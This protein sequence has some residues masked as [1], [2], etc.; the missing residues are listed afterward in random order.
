MTPPLAPA[1]GA[2]A[3]LRAAVRSTVR[4]LGAA[5]ALLYAVDRA[6]DRASRGRVRLF[7]YDLVAQ[8][9]PAAGM[10]AG[11]RAGGA[12]AIHGVAAGD[13]LTAAFPRPPEVIAARYRAGARCLAATVRGTF[14]GFLWWARGD[15]EEDEVRAT[16]VLADATRCAWDYDV[17][18]APEFRLGR[19]LARL[20][21]AA[22]ERLAADGVAWTLS[23]ISAF[24]AASHAAH[25]RL[26]LR[27]V[28]RA[29]FLRAGPVQLGLWTGPPF[30]HLSCSARSR[31]R[32]V[33]RAPAEAATD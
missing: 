13:P 9:V 11:L 28:G 33:L 3:G 14:A 10:G 1:A 12:T 20:W 4:E 21:Q 23:R 6:L 22:H 7:V 29:A 24:N 26:G 31:P 25:A 19:T 8:P 27:R 18:V 15:Y 2:P 32:I 17:Y 30:V 5:T 16:F